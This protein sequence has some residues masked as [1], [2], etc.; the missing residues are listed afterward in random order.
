MQAPVPDAAAAP[1]APYRDRKRLAWLFSLAVPASVIAGPLLA[2]WLDDA[3]VLWL[4]VAAFYVGVPLLD[5]LLGEDLSNPPEALV[6]ALDAD[7]Y[8]RRITWLLVPILWASF[9]FSGSSR[10]THC[11]GT[12]CWPWC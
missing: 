12:A 2:V 6:P 10:A 8:Y 3:R 5:L 4:P 9:V 11:P 1:A 7:P